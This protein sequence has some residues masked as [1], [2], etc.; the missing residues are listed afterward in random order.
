MEHNIITT[1]TVAKLIASH[2]RQMR[3]TPEARTSL[4]HFSLEIP[5]TQR[6]TTIKK[7]LYFFI[8]Q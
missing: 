3:Q 7:N 8:E 1:T 2:P 5:L 4:Y 6:K